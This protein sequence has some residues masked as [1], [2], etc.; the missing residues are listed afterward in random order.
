MELNTKERCYQNTNYVLNKRLNMLRK[1]M[2]SLL[3][4]GVHNIMQGIQTNV[5]RK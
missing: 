1:I 3:T 5:A 2:T 4:K